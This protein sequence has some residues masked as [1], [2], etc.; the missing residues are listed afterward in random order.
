M[1]ALELLG[2]E[3][4][5]FPAPWSFAGTE[6]P[7]ATLFGERVNDVH[8]RMRDVLDQNPGEGVY[9]ISLQLGGQDLGQYRST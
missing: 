7:L 5:Y 9:V 6:D 4:D 8:G 3:A 1:R 2:I